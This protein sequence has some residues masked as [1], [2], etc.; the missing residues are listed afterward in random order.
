M[1][2]AAVSNDLMKYSSSCGLQPPLSLLFQRQL[3]LATE[4]AVHWGVTTSLVIHRFSPNTQPLTL[5]WHFSA[6]F[7]F[8][9]MFFKNDFTSQQ[10]VFCFSQ[11]VAVYDYYFYFRHS[12]WVCGWWIEGCDASL[13]REIVERQWTVQ[14]R[15][16]GR[17][18]QL[19][20]G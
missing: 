16:C 18:K 12:N 8:K 9:L 15:R 7:F 17:F 2:H 20:S 3:C 13:F 10:K 19:P 11:S 1:R 5:Y 4:Q 14:R 6:F